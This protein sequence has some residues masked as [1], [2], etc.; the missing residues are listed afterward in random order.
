MYVSGHIHEIV[1]VDA[2]AVRY[3]ALHGSDRGLGVLLDRYGG[4]VWI[5]V[6]HVN[7]RA[8]RKFTGTWSS[9][10]RHPAVPSPSY[11]GTSQKDKSHDMIQQSLN[12]FVFYDLSQY[13][14][15]L[16][17]DNTCCSKR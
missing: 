7:L 10:M 1:Y 14:P 4:G 17:Y 15:I 5:Y 8:A 11:L 9:Y 16:G 3:T 12:I 2:D 6:Q 13:L